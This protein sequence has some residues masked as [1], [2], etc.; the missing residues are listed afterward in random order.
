MVLNNSGE[1][2]LM[3]MQSN[4][5]LYAGN[6][7][8]GVEQAGSTIHFGISDEVK[9]QWPLYHFTRPQQS[10]YNEDFN[11]YRLIWTTELIQFLI[12]GDIVGTA[13][14]DEGFWKAA[15][16]D[17]SGETNPWAQASHMAPF[18]QEFYVILNL[19]VGGT[20]YFSDSD[21][22]ENRNGK[23]PW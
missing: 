12:N 18:D 2:D 7:N 23:K 14:P 3:E 17:K 21:V 1:I 8:V 15:D 16:L 20:S 4:R 10:G 11:V 13:K 22:F 6:K 19:A 9:N 5:K